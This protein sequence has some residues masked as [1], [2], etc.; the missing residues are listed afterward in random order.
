[1]ATAG[2]HIPIHASLTQPILLGGVPRKFAV[3][4]GTIAAAIILGLHSFWGIPLCLLLHILAVALTKRE[5]DFFEISR[6]HIKQSSYYG[7]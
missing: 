4:N 2:F 3:L 5:P 1:M 6:R 7:V